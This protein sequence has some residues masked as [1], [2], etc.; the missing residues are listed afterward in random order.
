MK[1]SFVKTCLLALW[2]SVSLPMG[3]VF[4]KEPI[5][6]RE[7]AQTIPTDPAL[8]KGTLANGLQYYILQHT[9]PTKN[10]ELRLVV[11][12][13]S[14]NELEHER[15]ISHFLEHMVFNGTRLYPKHQLIDALENMGV[16][17]GTD[18][19]AYTGF[20]ETTYILPIPLNNPKNFEKSM[21]F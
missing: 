2:F 21:G 15:G 11:R 18:L 9:Q 17:F 10:V 5:S 12:A 20:D 19:N 7:M 13:G 4:A 6:E 3:L 1:Y 8:L 16:Q 14:V